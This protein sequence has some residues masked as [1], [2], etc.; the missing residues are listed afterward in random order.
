VKFLCAFTSPAFS[1]FLDNGNNKSALDE[2][3]K[4][5]KKQSDFTCAKTLK[6]LALIRLNR[7]D[8]ASPILEAIVEEGTA[9]EGALQ[10]MTLAFRE[11]QQ[12]K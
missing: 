5:L 3:N 10:A 8:E 1:D 11:L 2:A 6:A 7:E 9:D 12:R 4:V